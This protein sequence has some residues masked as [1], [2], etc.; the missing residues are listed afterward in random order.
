MKDSPVPSH[1]PRDDRI[2]LQLRELV[3]LN[4]VMVW[5]RLRIFKSCLLG[6]EIVAWDSS[7]VDWTLGVA[8]LRIDRVDGVLR[9]E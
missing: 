5:V 6:L 9:Y 7:N 4:Q 2:I 3:I 1:D 8:A